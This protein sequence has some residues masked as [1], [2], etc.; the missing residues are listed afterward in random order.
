M[1]IY[2]RARDEHWLRDKLEEGRIV[3]L[4]DESLWEVHPS[5][6][7]ATGRW[8]RLSTI[9][10]RHTTQK[11]GYPYLLTNS[12]EGETARAN[13]VT[14]SVPANTIKSEAA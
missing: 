14:E 6:R 2:P 8:L 12:T 3:V 4:D 9:T 11:E 10:V 1:S 7:P 13:Y 5:D